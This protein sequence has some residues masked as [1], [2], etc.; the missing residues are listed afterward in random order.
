MRDGHKRAATDNMMAGQR[1][2]A[3][4]YLHANEERPQASHNRQFSVRWDC[5]K[6]AVSDISWCQ[7]V[8]REV[9]HNALFDYVWRYF[10]GESGGQQNEGCE[11][12]A[13][14]QSGPGPVVLTGAQPLF[15]RAIKGSRGGFRVFLV[16]GVSGMGVSCV[17][18]ANQQSFRGLSS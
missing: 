13:N 8:Q 12:G 2:G 16:S 17:L 10:T 14:Q 11:P 6:R 15:W 3:L 1:L 7:N 4:V 18:G 9:Q 5:H